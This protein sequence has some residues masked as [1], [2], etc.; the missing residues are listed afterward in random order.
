ME[1][2]RRKNFRAIS[3]INRTTTMTI[4]INQTSSVITININGLKS[5]IKGDP[6]INMKM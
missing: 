1:E 3:L 4:K 6:Q 5:A 2:A